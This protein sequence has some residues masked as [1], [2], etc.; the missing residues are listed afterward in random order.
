MQL[1]AKHKI[2]F[3]D[4]FIFFS[5]IFLWPL[6]IGT[7]IDVSLFLVLILIRLLFSNIK[8]N[9]FLL[10]I[11]VLFLLFF[12][13]FMQ[14]SFQELTFFSQT[15]LIFGIFFAA[16]SFLYFMN[17]IFSRN[18]MRELI[19][20]VF[21][22]GVLLTTFL[23]IYQL[24]G[25][26]LGLYYIEYRHYFGNLPRPSG[27]FNE[28]SHL[29]IPYGLLFYIISNQKLRNYFSFDSSII[30][31]YFLSVLLCPSSTFFLIALIIMIINSLNLW[32]KNFLAFIFLAV[33]SFLFFSV[34]MNEE[35]FSTRFN[36][37]LSILALG[38]DPAVGMN[39][40]ALLLIKGFEMALYVLNNFPL[41]VGFLNFEMVSDKSIIS[42]LSPILAEK[43]NNDGTSILF[44]ILGEFGY[45]GLLFLIFFIFSLFRL[46]AQM[47]LNSSLSVMLLLP[48]LFCMVRGTSYFDG[49]ILISLSFYFAVA[50]KQK[51]NLFFEKY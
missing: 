12:F 16:I 35:Y 2:H 24:L 21:S 39:H 4:Q 36:D 19:V 20:N 18:G 11:V 5:C 41:G 25:D 30:L 26:L 38:E 28:P 46:S 44:K 43:N 10:S 50:F 1:S 42:T 29:A 14:A 37:V 45:I 49:L 9:F 47:T 7:G 40:S 33:I 32:F 17:N 3:F 51:E 6:K 15:R 31:I 13:T 27:M 8:T 23:Q 22:I 48:T 34:M